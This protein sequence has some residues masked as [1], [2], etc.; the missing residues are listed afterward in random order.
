MKIV[1]TTSELAT[2]DDGQTVTVT[3]TLTHLSTGIELR[4]KHMREKYLETPTYPTAVLTIPRASLAFPAPGATQAG[5]PQ[6]SVTIHGQTR[7]STFHYSATNDAAGYHVDAT[8]RVNMRDFGVVVPNY[9]GVSVKP[10]VDIDVH[11]S[12]VDH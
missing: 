7:P 3:V 9:M 4:D 12:A 11:F 10:D 2:S 5:D 1:G 8:L 6:A